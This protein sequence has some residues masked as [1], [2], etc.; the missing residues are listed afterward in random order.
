MTKH[1][2]ILI[3]LFLSTM[4]VSASRQDKEKGD[5]IYDRMVEL[6][7]LREDEQFKQEKDA[8]LAYFSE[9]GQW[10]HYYYVATLSMLAK[11]MYEGQTMAGLRECRQLYEFARDRQHDYGRGIVM[12][13]MAWLYGF[14]GDHEASLHQMREA[15]RILRRHPMSRETII[16]AYFYA[17]EL[18]LTGNYKE[19]EQLLK[20]AKPLMKAFEWGDKSSIVYRTY[21]DNFLNT[22]ALLEVRLGRMKRAGQLVNQ[23]HA[24]I[25][26][27]DELDPYEALRAIAEYYKAKGDLSMALAATDR[28]KPLAIN[29]GLQWGGIASYG[30]TPQTGA[31]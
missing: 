10:E 5:S 12:A 19:E 30:D 11:V 2:V 8:A 28:M 23:L 18:E 1:F 16:L 17:Y 29:S 13:Q 15:F 7:L 9:H 20:A 4:E 24:K 14:I 27:N 22:E 26:N 31:L 25:A 3:C 21:R 6:S